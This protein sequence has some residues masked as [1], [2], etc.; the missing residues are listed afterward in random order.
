M[1]GTGLP[2][3]LTGFVSGVGDRLSGR[4]HARAAAAAAAGSAGLLA[5]VLAPR[6]EIDVAALLAQAQLDATYPV[7][8]PVMAA[9]RGVPASLPVEVAAAAHVRPLLDPTAGALAGSILSPT[10]W[11]RTLGALQDRTVRR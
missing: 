6:P 9:D 11:R 1:G 5:D 2:A 4:T 3:S 7:A 10:T 8:V